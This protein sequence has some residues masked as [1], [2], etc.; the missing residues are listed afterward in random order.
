MSHYDAFGVGH[1]PH[2]ISYGFDAPTGGYWIDAFRTPFQ[3][4]PDISELGQTLTELKEIFIGQLGVT[5][6]VWLKDYQPQMIKDFIQASEPTP[7]QYKT[8]KLFGV[9]LKAKLTRV[10]HDMDNFMTVKKEGDPDE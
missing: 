9:D 7:L 4:H 8:K 5:E 3:E 10:L 1:P 2:S 6:E